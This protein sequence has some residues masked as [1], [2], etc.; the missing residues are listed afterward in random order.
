MQLLGS[1]HKIDLSNPD[2][3]PVL[4]CQTSIDPERRS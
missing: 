3:A 4:K 1:G 2:D